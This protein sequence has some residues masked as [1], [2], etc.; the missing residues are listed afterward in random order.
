[1]KLLSTLIAVLT[2]TV[3]SSSNSNAQIWYGIPIDST[4]YTFNTLDTNFDTV[5]AHL[6]QIGNTN[7]PFF[8]IDSILFPFF[9]S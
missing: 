6:W 4:I 7:K 8:A 2:I 5:G 3:Y 9:F 1:M